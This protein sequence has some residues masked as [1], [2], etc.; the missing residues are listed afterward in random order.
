VRALAASAASTPSGELG[1]G[2]CKPPV[3]VR[4]EAVILVARDER[5]Q[6]GNISR[7]CAPWLGIRAR[8][9]HGSV[10]ASIDAPRGP[11][12]AA[13]GTP[14][15][16]PRS[17]PGPGPPAFHLFPRVHDE[18]EAESITCLFS[19]SPHRG[20]ELKPR[21]LDAPLQQSCGSPSSALKQSEALLSGFPSC[22]AHDAS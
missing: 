14:G 12:R 9:M 1:G 18:P 7:P 20:L 3:L 8:R 13:R 17:A 6:D 11:A 19:Y 16:Q 2:S 15:P 5:A 4:L 22:F 21:A 10:R